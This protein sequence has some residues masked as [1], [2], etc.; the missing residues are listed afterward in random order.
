M[1]LDGVIENP[2]V[3]SIVDFAKAVGDFNPSVILGVG[4]GFSIDTARA[5][6]L[7]LQNPGVDPYKVFY[8]EGGHHSSSIVSE[9]DIPII[10]F[11]D[12]RYIK[13][14]P[15]F[16]IH[17]GSID[18]LAH[19]VESYLHTGSNFLNRSIGEIAFKLFAGFKDNMLSGKLTDEDYDNM[20]LTSF[21]AGISLCQ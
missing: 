1:V 7:L 18:A 12:S 16:L 20:I 21:I 9:A 13:K 19:A 11:L 17:T 5:L 2:P 14:S 15:A 6:S 3:E 8:V 10:A 4:G